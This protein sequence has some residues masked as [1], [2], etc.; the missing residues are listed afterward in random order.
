[1][2]NPNNEGL[3]AFVHAGDFPALRNPTLSSGYV[4]TSSMVEVVKF[5]SY[6]INTG[7]YITDTMERVGM[8]NDE[9]VGPLL[10]N[11]SRSMYH[12]GL[13]PK[14]A[15]YI[16]RENIHTKERLWGYWSREVQGLF[17]FNVPLRPV[18]FRD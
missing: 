1:M 11:F 13:D 16:I 15:R 18:Y 3:T 10:G 6:D 2:P 12:F 17:I 8:M 5:S 9:F 14:D 7:V 4:A